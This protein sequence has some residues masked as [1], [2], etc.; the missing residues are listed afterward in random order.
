MLAQRRNLPMFN[1]REQVTHL[2]KHNKV[3]IIQGDTGS[4]KT[5]QVPQLILD[6]LIESGE[7]EGV[8]I[9]CTQPRVVAAVSVATRVAD[10]RCQG[11]RWTVFPSSFSFFTL[12]AEFPT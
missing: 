12:I 5:T 3:C 11:L 6:A 10:E 4:G 1:H 9:V 2:V 8:G 7:C